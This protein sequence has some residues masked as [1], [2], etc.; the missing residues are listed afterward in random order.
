MVSNYERIYAEICKEAE[1]IEGR[2][3][4]LPADILTELVME[5]VDLEDQHR[6]KPQNINQKVENMIEQ[7]ARASTSMQDTSMQEEGGR[8]C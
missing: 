5:I 7:T 1:R 4:G 6:I 8:P 3:D 2:D